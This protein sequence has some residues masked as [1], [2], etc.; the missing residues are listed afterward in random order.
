M[1]LY[2]RQKIF[3]IGDK[4]NFTDIDGK[5]V[6]KAKKPV[7]SLTKIYLNDASGKELYLI[8]KKLFKIFAKYKVFKDGNEVLNIKRKF[9]IKP[10]F[11]VT[12]SE[13]NLYTV[14]GDFLAHDYVLTKNDKFI[15]AFRKK[16]IALGDSYELSV[17]DDYDPA[18]FCCFA[19]IIDN[20][21]FE[22]RNR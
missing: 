20:C 7:T 2:L 15:G 18:L 17:D 3:A 4:Y 13:G 11:E 1:N 5:I 12:D 6:Y 21:L 19:L 9:A 22:K 10:K 14:Q 16:Y 8:K